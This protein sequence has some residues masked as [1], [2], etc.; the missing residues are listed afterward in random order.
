MEFADM[1]TISKPYPARRGLFSAAGF[2]PAP[3]Q[4]VALRCYVCHGYAGTFLS[5]SRLPAGAGICPDCVV[6]ERAAMTE[7]QFAHMYG[8]EGINY[9]KNRQ[10]MHI[11]EGSRQ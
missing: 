6:S 11:E 4:P 2:I 5:W 3:T 1:L 8:R 10:S 9:S 7:V